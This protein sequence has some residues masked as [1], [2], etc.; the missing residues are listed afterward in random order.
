M[1]K[2]F[3][4]ISDGNGNPYYFDWKQRQRI[5]KKDKKF[6]KVESADSHS[7]L[8]S[9][10][11]FTGEKADKVNKYEYNPLTGLFTVDQINTVNDSELI[12]IVC[13]NLDFSEIVKPLIIHDIVNPLKLDRVDV[14]KKEIELL[15]VW[16]S[17]RPSVWASV[18]DSVRDSV[19]ASVRDSVWDSVGASVRDSVRPSVWASVRDSVWAYTSSFFSIKKWINFKGSK[20]FDPCIK[21]WNAGL[22]PSF[23]GK[24]W[25]LHG[26]DGKI[27]FSSEMNEL[28]KKVNK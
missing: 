26:K 25:R 23:D 17:V 27:V 24:I 20:P 7:S 14:T 2:F 16:A 12:K 15:K 4:L 9:F 3:S 11:G 21:L 19:G 18:R 10:Y 22:V 28:I 1:C 5:L 8:S 6:N 13:K